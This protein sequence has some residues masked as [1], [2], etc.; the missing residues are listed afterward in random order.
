MQHW[1]VLTNI[2]SS[3]YNRQKTYR[4]P[5]EASKK[6]RNRLLFKTIACKYR[7]EEFNG[8]I[9]VSQVQQP[10]VNLMKKDALQVEMGRLHA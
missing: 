4:F 5:S 7:I 10:L 3:G 8:G 2:R 9:D 1:K 6:V